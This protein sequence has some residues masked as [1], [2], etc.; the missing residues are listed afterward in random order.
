LPPTP[1]ALDAYLE[2]IAPW[3][4]PWLVSVQGGDLVGDR[5]FARYVVERGGHLQV[6]LEPNPDRARGNRELVEAAV[7][8]LT[9]VDRRPASIDETRALIGL[10]PVRRDAA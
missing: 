9:E 4:L 7:A 1:T 6:G 8:L 10:R 2:M 3:S 5:A